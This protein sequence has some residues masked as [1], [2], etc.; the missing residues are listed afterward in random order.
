M[1]P[2]PPLRLGLE[3]DYDYGR[4]GAWLLD[5]P[6]AF[7][8]AASAAAATSQSG[9]IA[10]WWR[11]WLAR[12]GD[13]WPLGL[14]GH[15]EIAETVPATV[16]GGSERNALFEHDRRPVTGDEVD[17]VLRRLQFA[18]ED[19]IDLIGRIEAAGSAFPTGSDRE[20]RPAAEVPAE[21]TAD[22]VLR[23][24]ARAEIWLASRLDPGA[25]YPG[26][27]DEPDARALLDATRPWASATLR[28][29]YDGDPAAAR[30]DSRGEAWTLAKVLRRVL[31]HSVDH[32]RE[33]DRR[34]ARAEDRGARLRVT[35]ERLGDVRPLVRLLHAV[36]WDRRAVEVETL[37]IAIRNTYAMVGAWDGDELVGFTR[38]LGDGVT[39]AHVSMV[40]VDPRWQGLGVADRLIREIM[41]DRPEIR[42]TL[43][44]AAGL[45]DFYRRFGFEPDPNAMTRRRRQ[46]RG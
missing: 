28:R 34:L 20:S 31:Y 21:R 25:R 19:L 14:I 38:E 41:G 15:G 5:L 36:G 9:S 23:H 8:W 4:V 7:G 35:R 33:L 2:I 37:E 32:L 16:E 42:F 26:P 12:H 45:Q 13:A 27:L 18:R 1:E 43:G 46:A 24:L 17:A 22:E 40:V 44:A 3:P 39:N 11:E 10:G 6:G 29:F 30:I